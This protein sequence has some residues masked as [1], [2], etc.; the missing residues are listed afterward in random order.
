MQFGAA[1]GYTQPMPRFWSTALAVI[2][3]GWIAGMASR[4][5]I[6]PAVGICWRPGAARNAPIAIPV[7]RE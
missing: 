4:S 3:I 2:F 5:A 6:Y 7:G 1:F